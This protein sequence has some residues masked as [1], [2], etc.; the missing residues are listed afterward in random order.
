MYLLRWQQCQ[1]SLSEA[2][3]EAVVIKFTGKLV[4]V[5]RYSFSSRSTTLTKHAGKIG[6]LSVDLLLADSLSGSF[7]FKSMRINNV[8]HFLSSV[9]H[10]V[11]GGD[12]VSSFE[13]VLCFAMPGE[14]VMLDTALPIDHDI[15]IVGILFLFL[16]T[17]N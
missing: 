5:L 9:V 2:H 8:L 6:G 3:L 10:H 13:G 1:R 12:E 11:V 14:D 17:N 7:S 4:V 16:F 15:I